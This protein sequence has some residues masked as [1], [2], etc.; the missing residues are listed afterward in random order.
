MSHA[1]F[2]QPHPVS[3]RRSK[4]VG[5]WIGLHQGA[6]VFAVGFPADLV[7]NSVRSKL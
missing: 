5:D 4:N 2:A 7:T 1:R 3:G 6:G